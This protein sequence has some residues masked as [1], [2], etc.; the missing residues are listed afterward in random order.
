MPKVTVWAARSYAVSEL[1]FAALQACQAFLEAAIKALSL[2][3]RERQFPMWFIYGQRN[4][5]FPQT[6]ILP[7]P[8]MGPR[9]GFDY[10]KKAQNFRSGKNCKD[11]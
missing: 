4:F 5:S 11:F 2:S 7:D 3:K 8:R 6:F 9:A 1:A 10:V